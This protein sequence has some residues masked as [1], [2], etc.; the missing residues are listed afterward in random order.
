MSDAHPVYLATSRALPDLD[1]DERLLLP[2]LRERGLHAEPRVWNDPEVDWGSARAVIVRTTWDYT[3]QVDEFRDWI[4]TTSA[5]TQ[6][7]NPPAA[8][9][10]NLRKEYLAQLDE[11]GVPTVPTRWVDRDSPMNL[12]FETPA[13]CWDQIVVKPV[14]GATASGARLFEAEQFEEAQQVIDEM[15]RE[16]TVLVQPFF[17]D[18]REVG[19]SSLIFINGELT[20]AVTKR[21]GGSDWRVQDHFGGTIEATAPPDSLREVAQEA[22]AAA[23]DLTG[24]ELLYARA[25]IIA[26][27]AGLPCLIELELI[28]PALF[29]GFGQGIAERLADAVASR[30]A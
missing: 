29:L 27:T 13:Y 12:A 5:L 23:R 18:V 28:E 10:W 15:S 20:H 14:V 25:D 11:R 16:D 4:R 2:A 22:L 26:D 6:L 21:P 24:E 1:P 17:P 7:L 8:L 3:T 30:L 9:E 19:E